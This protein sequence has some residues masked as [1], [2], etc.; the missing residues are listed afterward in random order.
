MYNILIV[1]D[2]KIERN[3]IRLLLKRMGADFNIAEASNGKE[4]LDYINAKKDSQDAPDILLTD[5]KMPFMDGIGLIKEVRNNNIHTKNIIFSGYNEFEYAKLAVRLGVVDYILKP[6]DPK[7]FEN[8]INRVICE[9]DSENMEKLTQSRRDDFIK[10]YLLYSMINGR[11]INAAKEL[12]GEG[13]YKQQYSDIGI[14]RYDRLILIEFNGDFLEKRLWILQMIF[15]KIYVVWRMSNILILT[16]SRRL[17][18]CVRK[19][20]TYMR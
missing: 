14:N 15:L 7:E 2:E 20:M 6:V 11:N 16:S 5:V 18:L 19:Q 12:A 9:L 1:D 17:Y 4:A 10:E 8:V 13:N 3:G